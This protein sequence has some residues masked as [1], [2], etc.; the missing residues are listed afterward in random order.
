MRHVE[1]SLR[2]SETLL[3]GA[4]ITSGNGVVADETCK[5]IEALTS[6]SLKHLANDATGWESLFE[7]PA[8]GRLWELY[9]PQSEMHGGGPPSL[10]NITALQASSKYKLPATS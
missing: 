3:K 10:R 9:Y 1:L 4:W 7:D 6:G 2:P 5:R 8:D